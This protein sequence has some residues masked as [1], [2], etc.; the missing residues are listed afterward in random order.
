VRPGFPGVAEAPTTATERGSKKELSLDLDTR[1][2][3]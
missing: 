3:L 1:N 2:L